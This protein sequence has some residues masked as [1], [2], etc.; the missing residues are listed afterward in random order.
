M[1][2]HHIVAHSVSCAHSFH[3]HV[4][5][6]VTCLSVRCWSSFCLPSL[7]LPSLSLPLLLF[8]S[9]H[10]LCPAHHLQCRHRR[11]LKPLHSRTMRSIA[12]WRKTIL[13]QK[14]ATCKESKSRPNLRDAEVHPAFSQRQMPS[15]VVRQTSLEQK[16]HL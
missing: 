8:H 9:R 12:P 14:V 2:L 13:S 4:I 10:V 5:H 7:C 16:Q 3:L 11:G 6:D 15:E 1:C